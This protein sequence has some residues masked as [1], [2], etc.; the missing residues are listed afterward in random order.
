MNVS[1]I[2]VVRAWKDTEY[3][4]GL[5]EAELAAL[6]ANP[7]G[8]IE[9]VDTELEGLSGGGVVLPP[10]KTIVVIRTVPPAC[11]PPTPAPPSPPWWTLGPCLPT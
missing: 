1:R 6:P 8:L 9:L 3:R 5:S 4:E 11:A 10:D 2:D 7:A